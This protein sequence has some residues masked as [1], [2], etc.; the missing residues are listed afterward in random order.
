M[1]RDPGHG[2]ME[3]GE[4]PELIIGGDESGRLSPTGRQVGVEHRADIVR[5]LHRFSS[6]AG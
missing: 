5:G 1:C 2:G 4:G 3:I 6:S